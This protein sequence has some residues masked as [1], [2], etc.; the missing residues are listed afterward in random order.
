MHVFEKRPSK[1]RSLFLDYL[2]YNAKAGDD[3]NEPDYREAL[4]KVDVRPETPAL[5]SLDALS[6]VSADDRVFV[7]GGDGTLN[8]I[9]R[10]CAER[11]CLIGVIPAGT[12]NDF[13]RGLGIPVD[14]PGAC[15]VFRSGKEVAIDIGVCDKS[16]FLNVA[17]I[18]AGAHIS[19]DLE[20]DAK[21]SLGRFSYFAKLLESFELKRGF[22]ADIDC[23]GERVTGRWLA[24]AVANGNSFGGG[25]PV[26]NAKPYDGE[27][28]VVAVRPQPIPT[29]AYEWA[30]IHLLGMVPQPAV[31][32]HLQGKSISVRTA[33]P[34]QV[35]ADGEPASHTPAE[36]SVKAGA[37][38]VIGPEQLE[39]H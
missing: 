24:I 37:L 30:R 5:D 20:D 7:A 6:V 15:E 31:I 10:S 28:D 11:G 19:A 12:A 25:Y 34:M 36:F 14:L 2:Y 3:A 33:S 9:A 27:L 35:S 8:Y 1:L 21:A 26:L 22:R 23:D 29:L 16:F 4:G 38:R 13:A 32:Q 18:G 17:H 39:P